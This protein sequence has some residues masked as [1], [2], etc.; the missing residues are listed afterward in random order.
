VYNKIKDVYFDSEEAKDIDKYI[1]R[2][3]ALKAK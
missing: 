3:N 1:T 2:V